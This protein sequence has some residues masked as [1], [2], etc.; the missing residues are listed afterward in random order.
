MG[1]SD[2]VEAR[3]SGAQTAA[4][5]RRAT[6][7][8]KVTFVDRRPPMREASVHHA[9][10]E[11]IAFLRS[12]G[13]PTVPV[14]ERVPTGLTTTVKQMGLSRNYEET[15]QP[16]VLS[17]TGMGWHLTTYDHRDDEYGNYRENY[18]MTER[19]I[20][21]FSSTSVRSNGPDGL[22]RTVSGIILP[23]YLRADEKTLALLT[24]SVMETVLAHVSIGE[25][26]YRTPTILD[27]AMMF[28]DS[29]K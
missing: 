3:I 29:F 4:E 20:A 2:R 28:P 7:A 14:W 26:P 9:A 27:A 16:S 17:Q 12:R 11:I 23:D 15:V 1:L 8:A 5:A 6:D 21:T 18:A 24:S 25:V 10:Q 22:P 19:G 13:I